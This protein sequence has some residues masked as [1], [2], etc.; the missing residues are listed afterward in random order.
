MKFYDDDG[1]EIIPDLIPKPGLCLSCVKDDD[2]S[3]EPFCVL[4]RF[5]QQD[6]EEFIGC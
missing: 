6:E 1:T 4:N 5:D 3:E 2:P